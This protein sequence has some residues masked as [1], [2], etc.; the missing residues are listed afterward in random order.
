MP[1]KAFCA[2]VFAVDCGEGSFLKPMKKETPR[3]RMTSPART[4]KK[5]ISL[6]LRNGRSGF[7]VGRAFGGNEVL[8]RH[9]NGVELRQI[10]EFG[11]AEVFEQGQR[12]LVAETALAGHFG[13]F[14][15]AAHQKITQDESRV[16]SADII[17]LAA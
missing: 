4:E 7:M 11:D 14:D 12:R 9:P 1:S 5:I 3:K 13:A 15:K 17:D 16:H 2:A 8:E 10:R 6:F